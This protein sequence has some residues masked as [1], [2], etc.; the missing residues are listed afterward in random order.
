M[1]P[2]WRG[3]RPLNRVGRPEDDAYAVPRGMTLVEALLAS[4]ILAVAVAA[5]SQAI[6]AG[7]MQSYSALHRRRAVDLAEALMEE[8]L[9]LPYNDPDGASAPGPEA[10]ESGRSSFDNIDDYHGFSETGGSVADLAGGTYASAFQGFS[11]SV[12]VASGTVTVGGVRRCNSGNDDCGDG[13]G[14]G[15]NELGVG[16]IRC[17]TGRI[18]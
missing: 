2:P 15:G 9:R 7:Q 6:V 11:R 4:V 8:V 3:L 14:W 12:T 10:G 18:G 16:A 17:G 13:N 1:N 5:V